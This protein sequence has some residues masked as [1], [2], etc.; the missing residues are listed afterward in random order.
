MPL[1]PKSVSRLHSMPFGTEIR[2]EGVQFRL[3]APEARKV[4]LVLE[5]E[6]GARRILPM[7]GD[8]R[9]WFRLLSAEAGTG[10]LYRFRIDDHL[11]VPDP[12]SRCQA[13]DI[14][15]PSVVIDPRSFPWQ[16]GSWRGRPWEEV[17]LYELHTGAFAP[18]GRFT[19]IIERLDYLAELGVTAIQLM[20]VADFPGQRNWGYDGA[21]LFAPDRAYGS[22]EELKSLVQAAHARNLMVF[23]D[24][25][26]NHF[27]PEGNYLH[28]YAKNAFFNEDHQTPWGAAINFDG[29]Q[30]DTVRR[31]FIDNALYW[32]EEYHLDGLRFDAV[33]A[34]FDTSSPHILEEIAH[35]AR[36]GPGR[37]RPIHLVLENDDNEARY[38]NRSPEGTC[39]LYNAQ[40]N[41]DFHH[42]CH[43]LL[44]GEDQGYY[45]DYSAHPL[46]LLGRCLTEGFAYQGG[47]SAYHNNQ[48]RGEPSRH[49]PP[50][51]FL[52]FLQNHDQ[53]GNRAFGERL[54]VLAPT[55][56]LRITVALLLLAPS[57][58]LLF[59]GEEFDATSPFLYFCDFGPDL[60][61]KVKE[62]RRQEFSR[63]PRFA[64]PEARA[65]IPDPNVA[66]TYLRS[67]LD[68]LE[69]EREQGR[70]CLHFYR[71]LL[72]LR[73]RE[74]IP[75]L[76]GLHGNRAQF[77]LIGN[78]GL[79]ACWIL[80]G[81]ARLEVFINYGD[82]SLPIFPMD[83]G[84]VLYCLPP[85]AG[86]DTPPTVLKPH[87]IIWLLNDKE[88]GNGK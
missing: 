2:P 12:V 30:R 33:H 67:R 64:D 55:P 17:I 45:R 1:H 83:G 31:F 57:P 13:E 69:A 35:A 26:Y 36:N 63:F 38:L 77:S 53:I 34:I 79:Q 27:G 50:T 48:P 10:S 60:A 42:A 47:P 85:A 82:T 23:L 5:Q 20:P 68:W 24:V 40:W 56:L 11:L 22:P 6:N 80:A 84:S 66:D 62:G 61:G 32:L 29:D 73:R 37:Q 74:I 8:D 16:D 70:E 86:H 81:A 78:H 4:D 3:W 52:A 58:P 19:G 87:S 18:D 49:L 21:L 44:T 65:C 7:I 54:A 43:V 72:R 59:M 76:T 75:R 28:V 39:R 88:T 15:G 41:D 51:A 14:H 46:A 9:G 25:V 71:H